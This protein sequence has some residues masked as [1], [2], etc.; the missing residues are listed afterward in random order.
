M[1]NN[2]KTEWGIQVTSPAAP[3]CQLSISSPL[4]CNLVCKSWWR[5]FKLWLA[6]SSTTV[7]VST[8]P[9]C[10]VFLPVPCWAKLPQYNWLSDWIPTTVMLI[11]C[12]YLLLLWFM[13]FVVLMWWCLKSLLIKCSGTL[14][15]LCSFFV[16]LIF[17]WNWN[18]PFCNGCSASFV[19]INFLN[20]FIVEGF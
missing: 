17:S 19:A 20:L 6:A 7:Q 9:P 2:C 11:N 14:Y 13:L 10:F 5:S 1:H 12:C 4:L 15:T 3:L 18:S 8:P 16:F